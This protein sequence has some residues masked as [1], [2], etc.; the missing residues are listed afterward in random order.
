MVFDRTDVRLWL[1]KWLPLV[2]AKNHTK[3]ESESWQI[4]AFP[5]MSKI[6]YLGDLFFYPMIY[7]KKIL[8]SK[9]G[10]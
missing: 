3:G 2:T 4:Y 1:P 7:T 8:K 10:A 9:F 6:A 5:L